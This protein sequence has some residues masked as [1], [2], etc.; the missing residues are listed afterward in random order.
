MD[1]H[2][3][4]E[5]HFVYF[6]FNRHAPQ[7]TE[8]VVPAHVEYWR[9]ANLKEYLGGPFTDRSGGLISFAASS[10]EEATNIVL[11]DPFIRADLVTQRWIK[12]WVIE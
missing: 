4:N 2:Q 1:D 3:S 10:L 12:E 8:E 6:Y 9:T 7:R 11:Q 5:R